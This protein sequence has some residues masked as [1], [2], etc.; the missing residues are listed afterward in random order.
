MNNS[1][2][3]P[4]WYFLLACL[5]LSLMVG[6]TTSSPAP[7]EANGEEQSTY[8]LGIDLLDTKSEFSLDS[9]GRLKTKVELSSADGRISLS[10]NEDTM[11]LDK[12]EGPLQVIDVAIDPNPPP[13]PKDTNIIGPVY[14]FSPEGATFDPFIMLTFSY[15]A[16]ELLEETRESNLY[17]GC[18][19]D[20][21][22]YMLRYKNLDTEN[23][24]VTTMTDRFTKYAVLA[25]M[26]KRDEPASG[27]PS[28]PADRVDVVYF[29]RTNRCYSCT[30]A[31]EMT[32]R[33]IE[34]YFE[35]ELNSGELT[36]KS[37]DVQD[38]SNAAIIEKY[39]AYTSSLFINSVRDGTDHIEP[40]MDIWSVL[41]DD[42]AFAE[43][44]K[45]NIQESLEGTGQ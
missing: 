36:F 14:D 5:A 40:V 7:P 32:R 3:K 17:V 43:V 24:R 12:E 34:T 42:E 10:L 18:Y 6:C 30:H 37:V 25:P 15:S 26:A 11:C 16:E 29:H 20:G 23:H 35:E 13:P 9:Q 31:E 45:G 41:G 2:I 28:A 8:Q 21:Q 38:D 33:T 44:V 1:V 22:W 27:V 4:R 19:V 39:N